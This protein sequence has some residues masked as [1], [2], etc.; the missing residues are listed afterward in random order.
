MEFPDLSYENI[1]IFIIF[2]MH[3]QESLDRAVLFAGWNKMKGL[4]MTSA[5]LWFDLE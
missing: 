5:G 1:N 3:L 2:T 4:H